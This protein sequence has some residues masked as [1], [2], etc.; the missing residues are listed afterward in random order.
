MSSYKAPL[1]SNSVYAGAIW[2]SPN[3]QRNELMDEVDNGVLDPVKTQ[4]PEDVAAPQTENQEIDN[5]ASREESRQDRN[6]RELR[7]TKD[8]WEKKARMQEDILQKLMSQQMQLPQANQA[9]VVEEDIF[10]DIAKDD[11]VP[12]EKVAKGLK[13]LEEKFDRR[14]QEIEKRYEEKHKNSLLNDL[15]REFPDFDD[16]VNTETLTLLE[17]HN[18]RLA[19][20][21]ASGRDPYNIAIQ[22]YE[23]IKAKGLAKT[24]QPQSKRATETERKIEQNKKTVQSPQAFDKRPMATAFEMTEAMKKELAKEMYGYAS[25]AGGGY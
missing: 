20:A 5:E 1:A 9:P 22:S 12:G 14:V 25:Q 6:W 18:P 24:A 15:K 19:N 21:I 11:Y 4:N 2:Y 3:Q 23:Y 16:V 17:E 8:E 13:K 7:R 10:G